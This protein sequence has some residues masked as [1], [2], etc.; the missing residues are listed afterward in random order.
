MTGDGL[1]VFPQQK[2]RLSLY[3]LDAPREHDN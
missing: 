3:A 2:G 1:W